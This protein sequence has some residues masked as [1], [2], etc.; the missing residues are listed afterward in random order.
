MNVFKSFA[1][2]RE[3]VDNIFFWHVF[4]LILINKVLQT[5][6]AEFH[7]NHWRI[8]LLDKI[9]Y[10]LDVRMMELSKIIYF[11]KDF[12]FLGTI[13]EGIKEV[14][15]EFFHGVEFFVDFT[16]DFD[17]DA[18]ASYNIVDDCDHF[19]IIVFGCLSEFSQ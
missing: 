16:L 5:S 13:N 15:V 1:Y 14:V 2:L 7:Y 19:L 9:L 12:F 4:A 8:V 18:L 11:P 17:D 6:V 3:N 10:L